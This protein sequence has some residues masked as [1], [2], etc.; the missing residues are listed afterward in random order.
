[1]LFLGLF[2]IIYIVLAVNKRITSDDQ[3]WSSPIPFPGEPSTLVYK[4]E[5]LQRIWEWEIA[6]GHYPSARRS[7][8]SL[9]ILVQLCLIPLYSTRTNWAYEPAPK[10]SAVSASDFSIASS[11][12]GTGLDRYYWTWP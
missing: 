9:R 3:S 1:M 6:S 4:R 11:L 7:T 8:C 5:D 12:Q 10:P 2:A